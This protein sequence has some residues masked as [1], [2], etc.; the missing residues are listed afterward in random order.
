MGINPQNYRFIKIKKKKK[1]KKCIYEDILMNFT[2]I[3][4]ILYFM[5]IINNFSILIS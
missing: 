1:I 4:A 3:K 5:V 2:F